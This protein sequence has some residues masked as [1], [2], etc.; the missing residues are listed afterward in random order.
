MLVTF[1]RGVQ[2]SRGPAS[3]AP[4]SAAPASATPDSEEPASLG[5]A[6][7]GAASPA[8]PASPA[9]GAPASRSFGWQLLT[10]TGDGASSFVLF[11]SC[12]LV[13]APQHEAPSL[14]AAHVKR[15]PA[16]SW[17]TLAV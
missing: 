3:A 4:A 13:L 12:P 16:L 1:C 5:A 17:V 6:S 2:I 8:S 10:T 15:L 14:V 7:V 11:P 9:S